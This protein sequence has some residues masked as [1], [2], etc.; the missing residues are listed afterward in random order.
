MKPNVMELARKYA[1]LSNV[2]RE[3]TKDTTLAKGDVL[4]VKYCGVMS[5]LIVETLQN[6]HERMYPVFDMATTN[7]ILREWSLEELNGAD[8]VEE[9]GTDE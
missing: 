9:G 1:E 3:Y 8:E 5:D 2:C 4:T 6:L 7:G